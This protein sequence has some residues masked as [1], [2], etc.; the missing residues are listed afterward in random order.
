MFY[1][2]DRT[3]SPAKMKVTPEVNMSIFLFLAPKPQPHSTRATT[4]TAP[5][6][7]KN[8][9]DLTTASEMMNAGME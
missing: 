6:T 4:I 3:D 5:A 8:H 7:R 2:H 9:A 1:D